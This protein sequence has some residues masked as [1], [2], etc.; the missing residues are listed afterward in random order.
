MSTIEQVP[1][2]VDVMMIQGDSWTQSFV[3]RDK[4]TNDPIDASAWT[5]DAQIRSN[6]EPSNVI[7]LDVDMTAATTGT[8][9]IR[10]TAAQ[11]E[12]L[13]A[14]NVWEMQRTD[15]SDVRTLIAGAFV[16]DRQVAR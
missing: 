8:I 6:N 1:A 5:V 13:A 10:L 3:F 2:T 12:D 4:T 9:T 14:R 16:A 11:S 15:T 7:D